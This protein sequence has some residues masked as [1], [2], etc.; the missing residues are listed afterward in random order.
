MKNDLFTRITEL[1]QQNKTFCIVTVVDS[2][3]TTPRKAGARGLIFPDGSIEGTVGGGSIES[4]A[5][6]EAKRILKIGKPLLKS[7]DLKN[8]KNEMTCGG[9]MT[10]YYEP[11]L[12]EKMATIFGGGHVGRAVAR[13]AS[14]AG[15]RVVVVDQRREILEAHFFPEGTEL[16]ASDF[17]GYIQSHSFGSHDWIIIVTP[18]HQYDEEVLQLML[19]HPVAYL[20]MM[21]S[22]QKI[23]EVVKN[24]RRKGISEEQLAHVHTPIGLNIGTETPGEIAVAIVAEMQAVLYGIREVRSCSGL[25]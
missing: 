11:V 2:A 8:L 10:L 21:G 12:P 9:S 20:G 16:I 19:P 3:G 22:P 24:L 18:Q 13:V 1:Q 6:E 17:A 25:S 4:E 23:R 14:I 5:I 7:Y 15:W